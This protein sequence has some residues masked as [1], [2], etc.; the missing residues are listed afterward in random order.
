MKRQ[1]AEVLS[2][3]LDKRERQIQ[4]DYEWALH[5]PAVRKKHGG[6]VVVVHRRQVWGAGKDHGAAWVAA[7]RKRGCPTRGQVAFV[8]VP[9]YIPSAEPR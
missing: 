6:K 1:R 4:D 9:D 5:D 8:I 2:P 3:Y 7:S